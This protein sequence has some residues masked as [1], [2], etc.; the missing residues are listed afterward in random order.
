M[1]NIPIKKY[2]FAASLL[3]LPSLAYADA[4]VPMLVL[5]MPIFA[6]SIIP[7]VIIEAIYMQRVLSIPTR[8]AGRASLMANLVSTLVGI[9]MTW[10]L[11]VILQ[12]FTGGD[13]AYGLDSTLGKIIAVTWQAPW[14]IPYEENFNWML[15]IAGIVLL[16]PFYFA[17]WWSEYLTCEK[18]LHGIPSVTLKKCMR[19]ANM[20]TYGLMILWPLFFLIF[21]GQ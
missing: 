11:L 4:G 12:F 20:I 19:N 6:L 1:Q 8:V 5:V 10:I 13:K 17:S 16:I 18:L 15:P 21:P 14:L 3:L 9:P 7:I 2:L